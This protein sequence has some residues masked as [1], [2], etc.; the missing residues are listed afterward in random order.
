M[1][2]VFD[3]TINLGHVL[4]FI[5]FLLTIVI[6]F[7]ALDKRVT[8]V[9]QA[10]VYQVRRDAEQDR[11]ISESKDQVRDALQDVHRSL[12]KLSD[13]IDEKTKR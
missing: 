7:T 1:R 3:W 10:Q 11:V 12:E 9:E 13:K 8:V 4:T 2:P 5:G 6:A